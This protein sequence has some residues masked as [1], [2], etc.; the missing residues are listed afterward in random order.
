MEYS[1]HDSVNPEIKRPP[2]YEA[3]IIKAEV[4]EDYILVESLLQD[5]KKKFGKL[6]DYLC[7][8]ETR[9]PAMKFLVEAKKALIKLRVA[10]NAEEI[11]EAVQRTN[12]VLLM[13]PETCTD[14]ADGKLVRNL[15]KEMVE[16]RRIL[17]K[18]YID[19]AR[20]NVGKAVKTGTEVLLN[21][22]RDVVGELAKDSF[23]TGLDKETIAELDKVYAELR[24]QVGQG[25]I[26]AVL[27]SRSFKQVIISTAFMSTA[28]KV[29]SKV[30]E[31]FARVWKS[32]LK[33][34]KKETT[35][36]ASMPFF[37]NTRSKVTELF[38]RAWRSM[39]QGWKKETTLTA[40]MPFLSNTCSKTVGLFKQMGKS[41][42]LRKI[43]YFCIAAIF[44]LLLIQYAAKLLTHRRIKQF[45]ASVLAAQYEQAM[46]I[47]RKIVGQ[48]GPAEIYLH[49]YS[50]KTVI[51]NIDAELTA[52]AGINPDYRVE[53]RRLADEC[54]QLLKLQKYTE[55]LEKYTNTTVRV[56]PFLLQQA[57]V[58]MV[59]DPVLPALALVLS[60]KK[61][62]VTTTNRSDGSTEISLVA[63]DW[64][65]S[66]L[67]D[68]YYLPENKFQFIPGMNSKTLR[69]ERETGLCS[70]SADGISNGTEVHIVGLDRSFTGKTGESLQFLSGTQSLT[71]AVSGYRKK[72]IQ[73][74]IPPRGSTNYFITLE[75]EQGEVLIQA[76]LPK[77]FKDSGFIKK[78]AKLVINGT[79]EANISLPYL[80]RFTPGKYDISL[81]LQKY[82]KGETKQVSI[83]DKSSETV[84]FEMVPFDADITFVSNLSNETISIYQNNKFVGY[85]GNKMETKPFMRPSFDFEVIG[86]EPLRVQ[87]TSP[88]E[89]GDNYIATI[90]NWI[91]AK[92]KPVDVDMS[93]TRITGV[94][95]LLITGTINASGSG[96]I[97]IN[98]Q[99]FDST[100]SA[101][102]S[103][104]I[105]KCFS[106]PPGEY[107]VAADIPGYSPAPSSGNIVQV[108]VAAGKITNQK[109]EMLPD[110]CYARFLCRY[111]YADI[112][113]YN[114]DGMIGKC[115][116]WIKFRPFVHHQ[117]S[118]I[119]KNFYK[120]TTELVLDKPG[121]SINIE[122]PI[123][124]S[125]LS[126]DRMS[127][128]EWNNILKEVR[129]EGAV[130]KT[131]KTRGGAP[132]KSSFFGRVKNY[133]GLHPDKKK[134]INPDDENQ[135]FVKPP[136]D[137]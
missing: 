21:N 87:V 60:N 9:L 82:Q 51:A 84:S 72:E 85:V 71:L 76:R 106:V 127:D 75:Q 120:Y 95:R 63:G 103:G 28:S 49:I 45:E 74:N 101:D 79:N 125:G 47:A 20:L 8:I 56:K 83:R 16:L 34:R 73:V 112:D 67:D 113:I 22:A 40:P 38:A 19:A 118:F 116:T 133:L 105:V 7:S 90:T 2:D 23:R 25:N 30:T 50:N 131:S 136:G 61:V 26:N 46:V 31:L 78:G 64:E 48:Y 94:L 54:E 77:T 117:L 111:K 80:A 123:K 55:A 81:E 33:G 32:I 69:V 1:N 115:G 66:L 96:R 6:T 42:L 92:V 102:T 129:P 68:R 110:I 104:N 11:G 89:P 137:K 10:K 93:P 58:R 122:V 36:P 135:Q 57:K 18:E 39:L 13:S 44:V 100:V 14:E 114:Q 41:I 97:S 98:D 35:R 108:T 65:I 99:H 17:I 130:E 43:I 70:I 126:W 4:K 88:L 24:S 124:P 132:S 15:S 29:Y 121:K 59:T 53:L 128:Y 12:T 62:S 52:T 119:G 91:P 27:L 107:E 134:V 86:Y 3:D 109:Y 5:Y 37:S